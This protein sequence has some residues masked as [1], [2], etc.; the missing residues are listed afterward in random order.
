MYS[1]EKSALNLPE[2]LKLDSLIMIEDSNSLPVE[3]KLLKSFFE[4]LAELRRISWY[5]TT[6][7]GV[8][9][10]VNEI[11]HPSKPYVHHHCILGI[12]RNLHPCIQQGRGF[13]YCI[14]E[15]L[16]EINPPAMGKE[17][18]VRRAVVHFFLPGITKQSQLENKTEVLLWGMVFSWC[19]ENTCVFPC[20]YCHL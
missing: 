6:V 16:Q 4:F 9:L 3:R 5:R 2:R 11:F 17:V 12:A 13:H 20:C 15:H 10:V 1:P 7:R 19:S 18:R 14:V 8:S